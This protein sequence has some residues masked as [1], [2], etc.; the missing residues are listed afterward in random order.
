MNLNDT[1]QAV[2]A[3][4]KGLKAGDRITA[5]GHEAM[6]TFLYETIEESWCGDCGYWP[7]PNTELLMKIWEN[8]TT[9]HLIS[10]EL[11]KAIN[12]L[13]KARK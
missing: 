3:A 10:P 13:E 11:D 1:I 5:E 9:F 6:D 12:E 7:N 8:K 4:F 2:L